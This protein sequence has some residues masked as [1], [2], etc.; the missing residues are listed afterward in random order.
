L[1]HRLTAPPL[2]RLKPWVNACGKMAARSLRYR[3]RGRKLAALE[4]NPFSMHFRSS[5]YAGS[6]IG[7]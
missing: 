3:R 4:I 5:G 7:G 1:Q 6:V 2:P